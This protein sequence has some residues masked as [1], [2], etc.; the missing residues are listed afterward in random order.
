MRAMLIVAAWSAL[1]FGRAAADAV[2][3]HPSNNPPGFVEVSG[4]AAEDL[5]AIGN[6]GLEGESWTK[7][8]AVYVVP[9]QGK[10]VG[11]ALAGDYHLGDR[12]LRFTPRFPLT[13]GVRYRAVFRPRGTDGHTAPIEKEFSLAK[14]KTEAPRVT[15]IYPTGDRLPENQLKFYL[16]FSASMARGDVY[17]H[18]KLLDDRGKPV[19]LPFLE[20]DEE[21]WDGRQQRLTLFCDP[22]RIKRGLKP[23]EEVG[24]VF[25]EG[26]RYTLVVDAGFEDANGNP[27]KEPYRKAFQALA[28]DDTQPD[29]KNWKLQSPSA[30][31]RDPLTVTFPKPLDEALL[32]RL[33]WVTDDRSAKVAGKVAVSGQETLWQFTP[34]E[35]WKLGQYRLVADT[36]LEDLAGNS[37]A[38]PFEVDV[39]HPV[40][41]EV[42][43]ETVSV[44]FAVA[45]EKRR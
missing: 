28:P 45:A 42:K 16:H 12:T 27:L 34:N 17:R 30:G 39:F 8:F 18:V 38:R 2:K 9:P 35:S 5:T 26:K 6:L 1:L 40:Q 19:D 20:L 33:V 41:R 14:P 43:A 37:I 11:P 24:P 10:H 21:L 3:I 4:L 31:T 32:E 7:V 13:P 25:E 15:H 23:R 36:R 22:G 29:P 44:P